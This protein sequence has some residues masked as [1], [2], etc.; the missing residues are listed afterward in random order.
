MLLYHLRIMHFLLLVVMCS[1]DQQAMN[2]V[3]KRLH[4]LNLC[5]C[6]NEYKKM[7]NS[8]LFCPLIEIVVAVYILTLFLIYR[9]VIFVCIIFNI[10]K[11]DIQYYTLAHIIMHVHCLYACYYCAMSL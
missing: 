8:L 3:M 1:A 6:K 7:V 9:A 2:T 11:I 4:L 10:A 5:S